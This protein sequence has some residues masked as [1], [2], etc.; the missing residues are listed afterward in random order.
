MNISKFL[1]LIL[2]ASQVQA[3]EPQIS[4]DGTPKP[5]NNLPT[6]ATPTKSN[7]IV[8]E[9]NPIEYASQINVEII[10]FQRLLDNESLNNQ[11]FAEFTSVI[12]T[13]DAILPAE[14]QINARTLPSN[15][16]QLNDIFTKFQ[17]HEAYI[18]FYHQAWTQALPQQSS[19]FPIRIQSIPSEIPAVD[20]RLSIWQDNNIELNFN[21][22][23]SYDSAQTKNGVSQAF[24]S[25]NQDDVSNT[26]PDIDA[27]DSNSQTDK[28]N[29]DP[30][31]H[32]IQYQSQSSYIDNQMMYFDHPLFGILV[33]INSADGKPLKGVNSNDGN[34]TQ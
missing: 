31:R 1:F 29:R 20:G 4:T 19:A 9:N 32:T 25:V 2:L 28:Q 30:M 12:P 18:P 7:S 34:M 27:V 17:Q 8:A 22:A 21:L 5:A 11:K 3:N 23:F 13:A 33:L 26:V 16:M 6:E 10:V 14:N 24:G 15:Q